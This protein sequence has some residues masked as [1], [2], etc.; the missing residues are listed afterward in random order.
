VLKA[1]I[2]NM[3][4]TQGVEDCVFPTPQLIWPILCESSFTTGIS[5]C[6]SS[7]YIS[8]VLELCFRSYPDD[9]PLPFDILAAFL[10]L[11]RKYAI[12]PLF[13]KALAHLTV[14]FSSSLDQYTN[15]DSRKHIAF[16]DLD[17]VQLGEIVIN[18]IVLAHEL[19]LPSL[20]LPAAFWFASVRPE[21]LA[22]KNTRSITDADRNAILLVAKL[23]HLA[24]AN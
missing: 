20:I 1:A 17:N 23:L 7:F 19:H 9:E 2:D 5:V 24:H 22:H 11:G 14:T 4:E 21:S 12:K 15:D 13:A 6:C 8:G 18:T 16:T 3:G 10:R